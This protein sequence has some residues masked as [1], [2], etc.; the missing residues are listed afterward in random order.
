MHFSY[1]T[2]DTNHDGVLAGPASHFL[3]YID[4]LTELYS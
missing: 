3:I 1:K 4:L 2:R